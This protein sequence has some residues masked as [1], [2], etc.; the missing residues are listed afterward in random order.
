MLREELART[1]GLSPRYVTK[2]ANTASHHY[3]YFAIRKASGGTRDIFHPAKPLKAVQRWLQTN[4]VARLPLHDAA[5]AY[6]KD[7]NIA[8]HARRHLKSRYLVRVDLADFFESITATDIHPYLNDH[9][10]HL[11]PGWDSVDD[12]LFVSLVCRHERLTIGAITSPGLSNALCVPLDRLLTKHC[13]EQDITYTRYA[14]D[15]FFSCAIPNVLGDIPALVETALRSIPYPA[16]L[17]VNHAK[18]RHSSLKRRRRVTGI[19]LSTQGRISLGRHFKRAIRSQIHKM[20]SLG[21]PQRKRLAGLLAYVK[22]IEPEFFNRLVLRYGEQVAQ[23][24]HFK[25]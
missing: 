7:H 13:V 25:G 14:D 22:D 15:M 10:A 19:V 9:L 18:T 21:P 24:A 4:V 20:D 17:V 12:E 16:G 2:L 8:D 11:P 1:L 6:R 3:K 5:A 23:A